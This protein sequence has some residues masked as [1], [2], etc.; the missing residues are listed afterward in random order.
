MRCKSG[1]SS[2]PLEVSGLKIS[3]SHSNFSHLIQKLRSVSFMAIR[4]ASLTEVNRGSLQRINPQRSGRPAQ[5][6]ELSTPQP[7]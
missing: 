3:L 5:A 1:H 7:S 6:H 4:H 2:H